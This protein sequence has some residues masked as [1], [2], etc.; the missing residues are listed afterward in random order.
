MRYVLSIHYREY[1]EE[2]LRKFVDNCEK[3][4]DTYAMKQS[5]LNLLGQLE[6]YTQKH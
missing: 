2:V 4:N 6:Q 1:I 3:C 5:A